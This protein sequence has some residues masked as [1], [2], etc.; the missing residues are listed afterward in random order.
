MNAAAVPATVE[1]VQGDARWISIHQRFLLE[2][3]EREP[4]VLFVGDSL[5]AHLV[6]T[7]LWETLFEPLHPLN[8]GI[9]GDQ[10]QHVLWRLQNGE[11]DNIKPKVVVL[12]VGTNNHG[13][14][15]EMISDGIVAIVELIREK[16]PQ[17]H[18]LTL[19]LLPRGHQNNPLRARNSGVNQLLVQKLVTISRCQ[20]ISTEW[21]G[22]IQAGDQ[23][24]SHLDM[25]DYL[26]LTP[27]GYR[28]VFEPVHE[29]LLQLLNDE[30]G[31]AAAANVAGESSVAAAGV[32]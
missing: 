9:G 10:T 24:I 32:Q 13:H 25:Y 27:Q 30:E 6:Y 18:V 16:Q 2:T 8:F 20:L 12:L 1:D 7:D 26:H 17:A 11:L 15:P 4:E 22:F 19:S 31:D 28:K 21:S 14:T 23:T 3:K 5:I 29:L